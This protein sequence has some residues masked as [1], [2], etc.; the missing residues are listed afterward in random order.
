ML[1][2]SQKISRRALPIRWE[3]FLW[4]RQWR[5][6][7]QHSVETQWSLRRA[8]AL[9]RRFS[10]TKV[11]NFAEYVCINIIVFICLFTLFFW[12]NLAII[13]LKVINNFSYLLLLLTQLPTDLGTAI[14]VKKVFVFNRYINK[15]FFLILVTFFCLLDC[16]NF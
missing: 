2:T 4:T 15:P 1:Q 6:K 8:P 12:W 3:S 5:Q 9:V 16:F 10:A 11:C 13:I 7:P 14:N